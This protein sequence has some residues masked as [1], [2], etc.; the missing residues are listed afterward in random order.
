MALEKRRTLG[1]FHAV[2]RKTEDGLY[3][4]EY[5]GEINPDNPDAREIPDMH[6]GTSIDEVKIWVEQMARGLGYDRVIWDGLPTE[7]EASNL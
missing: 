1:N 2:L 5:S 7:G 6:I 4:A 3:R